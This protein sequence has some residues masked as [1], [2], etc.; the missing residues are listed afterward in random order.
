MNL[1]W[2]HNLRKVLLEMRNGSRPESLSVPVIKEIVN[3]PSFEE[4]SKYAAKLLSSGEIEIH[5]RVL[6][7]DTKNTIA[8]FGYLYQVPPQVF[9]ESSDSYFKINPIKDVEII[10]SVTKA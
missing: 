9:D 1:G 2:K 3:A 8:E 10:Y 5:Y 7:P 6:S 4:L